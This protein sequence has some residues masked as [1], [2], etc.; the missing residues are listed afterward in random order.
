MDETSFDQSSFPSSSPSSSLVYTTLTSSS[1]STFLSLCDGNHPSEPPSDSLQEGLQRYASYDDVYVTSEEEEED[2]EDH[3][4][5]WEESGEDERVKDGCMGELLSGMH[6]LINS[7]KKKR[8]KKKRGSKSPPS[9]SS[10]ETSL[11][12]SSRHSTAT[13]FSMQVSRHLK[14]RFL[15]SRTAWSFGGEYHPRKLNIVHPPLRCEALVASPEGISSPSRSLL[16]RT[17]TLPLKLANQKHQALSRALSRS[18]PTSPILT[19]K[20]A[21]PHQLLTRLDPPLP[22]RSEKMPRKKNIPCKS[23]DFQSETLAYHSPLSKLPPKPTRKQLSQ[24]SHVTSPNSLVSVRKEQVVGDAPTIPRSPSSPPFQLPMVSPTPLGATGS[25]SSSDEVILEACNKC[26]HNIAANIQHASLWG[27]MPAHTPSYSYTPSPL[28][29]P[30]PSYSFA[31]SPKQP[32]ASAH[33]FASPTF[34]HYTRDSN[35]DKATDS[36]AKHSKEE[37]KLQ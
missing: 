28:Q 13:A 20:P 7:H 18:Q 27:N 9:F 16:V 32:P 22:P 30:A 34:C 6:P 17:L 23:L 12:S 33:S 25:N 11:T 4:E 1:P 10:D 29:P 14:D 2:Q 3:E 8:K 36:K 5:E 24:S 19:R 15:G 21:G 26:A 35:F 31:S 37:C